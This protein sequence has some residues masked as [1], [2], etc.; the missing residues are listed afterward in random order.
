MKRNETQAYKDYHRKYN[1]E[2]YHKVRNKAIEMLGGKCVVCGTTMNLE[3][4]HIEPSEKKFNIGACW[5][6][7]IFYEEIKKCQLLCYPCHLKKTSKEMRAKVTH[8]KYHVAYRLK[9]TC[10]LCAEYK[11]TYNKERKH[12]RS[13]TVA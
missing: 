4:D 5:S 3:I 11:K 1:R 12:R 7:P 2:R 8:G 9:C 10:A 6:R 13:T